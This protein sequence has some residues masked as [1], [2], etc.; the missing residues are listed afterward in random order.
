MACF[1]RSGRGCWC[2]RAASVFQKLFWQ[3]RLR[4]WVS[5]ARAFCGEA[6]NRRPANSCT[7]PCDSPNA[8]GMRASTLSLRP[9]HQLLQSRS[10]A[11]S[12]RFTFASASARQVSC[13]HGPLHLVQRPLSLLQHRAYHSAHVHQDE[14]TIYALSTASGK[15]AI[16]VIRISGSACRQVL[17]L[18]VDQ[19]HATHCATDI[20]KAL[21]LDS[22][23]KATIRD[24]S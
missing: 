19:Q 2:E 18:C 6:A 5:S 15:A 17:R 23:P 1:G 3:P 24:T 21:S 4:E 11:P 8:L 22:L 10:R 20:R 16:A 9:W 12:L 14:P 13:G 7:P